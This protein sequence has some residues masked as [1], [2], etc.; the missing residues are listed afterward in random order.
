MVIAI[1]I[2]H[3]EHPLRDSSIIISVLLICTWGKSELQRKFRHSQNVVAIFETLLSLL[4][5]GVFAKIFCGLYGQLHFMYDD[6]G[7]GPALFGMLAAFVLFLIWAICPRYWRWYNLI[8]NSL[9]A[10]VTFPWQQ[11]KK[12]GVIWRIVICAVMLFLYSWLVTW[13]VA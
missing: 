2:R 5:F 1:G 6:P 9:T 7:R 8:S 13:A 11:A 12:T 10:F 4:I 3:D